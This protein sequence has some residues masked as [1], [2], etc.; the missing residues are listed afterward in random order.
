MEH[1]NSEYDDTKINNFS[2]THHNLNNIV[3][4][5][6]DPS[7]IIAKADSGASNHYWMIR[8]K[9]VLQNLLHQLGPTVYLPNNDSITSNECGHLPIP[10]LKSS[11]T[12][13]H[14]LPA[15]QNSSL[16]SLGQ[17]CDDDCIV[18]LTKTNLSVFKNDKL[19]L[20]GYRNQHDGL[21]GVPLPQ[22]PLHSLITSSTQA[23]PPKP[24]NANVIIRKNTTKKDLAQYLHA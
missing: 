5:T 8:D 12:K 2:L 6:L 10:N 19:I 7:V 17:L 9:S 4:S 21:W 1:T 23:S 14:I 24:R 16:I 18:H 15:L 20:S 13:T 3:N 22:S 11:S